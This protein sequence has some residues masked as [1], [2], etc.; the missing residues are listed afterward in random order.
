MTTTSPTQPSITAANLSEHARQRLERLQ[1]LQRI[2]G[3]ANSRPRRPRRSPPLLCCVRAHRAGL[4]PELPPAP[5][6]PA[7]DAISGEYRCVLCGLS[8]SFVKREEEDCWCHPSDHIGVRD[9]TKWPGGSLW[10]NTEEER[11]RSF[12]EREESKRKSF[13]KRKRE[14]EQ[15][16]KEATRKHTAE[17]EARARKPLARLINR[18]RRSLLV[19]A[20]F[21]SFVFYGILVL[22]ASLK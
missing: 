7:R 14:E 5:L 20:I 13:E 15:R 8:F 1:A 18:A 6:L 11:A 12:R 21:Y 10:D 22:F 9:V 16:K 19:N 3:I 2:A 17:R 4:L